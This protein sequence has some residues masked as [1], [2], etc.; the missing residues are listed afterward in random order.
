MEI[1]CK[2]NVKMWVYYYYNQSILETR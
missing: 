2:M 1:D